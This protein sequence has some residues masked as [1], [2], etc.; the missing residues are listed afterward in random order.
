MQQEGCCAFQG[1][2]APH[3]QSHCMVLSIFVDWPPSSAIACCVCVA[4]YTLLFS[5][6]FPYKGGWLLTVTL[7]DHHL[8]RS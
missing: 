1:V 6:Q 7:M 8:D 5:L 3:R 4:P 2:H